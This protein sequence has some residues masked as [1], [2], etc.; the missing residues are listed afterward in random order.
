ML[1]VDT[2][3][4]LYFQ[5]RLARHISTLLGCVSL[6]VALLRLRFRS[7]VPSKSTARFNAQN[8]KLYLRRPFVRRFEALCELGGDRSQFFVLS[9]GLVLQRR[10]RRAF[11]AGG[12]DN[13]GGVPTGSPCA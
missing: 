9:F 1:W 6:D 3:I 12:I 13:L 10:G 5:S 8:T 2:E 11:G 4:T 7:V